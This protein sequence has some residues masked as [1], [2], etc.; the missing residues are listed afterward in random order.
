MHQGEAPRPISMTKPGSPSRALGPTTQA[1]GRK[2][3]RLTVSEVAGHVRSGVK[4]T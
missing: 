3:D 1:I 2:I 4:V